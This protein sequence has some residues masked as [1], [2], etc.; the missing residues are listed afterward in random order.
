MGRKRRDAPSIDDALLVEVCQRFFANERAVDIAEWLGGALGRKFSRESIYPLLSR[1]RQE[2]ILRIVA[3]EHIE[4]QRRMRGGKDIT[5]SAAVRLQ[6]EDGLFIDVRDLSEYKNGHL[7]NAKHIALKELGE[8]MHELEKHKDKPVIAYC[9]NGMRAAKASG[10]L[11]KN[12]FNQVFSLAGGLAA[13]EKANL[14]VE[15]K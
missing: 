2:G 9:G 10:L 7:L 14:P 13:W 11:V 1:A 15:K 3:P 12:G 5:P 4:M 8:R 6:N